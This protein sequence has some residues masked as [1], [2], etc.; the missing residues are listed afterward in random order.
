M[1]DSILL[2]KTP[3]FGENIAQ[4]KIEQALHRGQEQSHENAYRASKLAHWSEIRS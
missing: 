1:Q 3:T 2:A 4:Y